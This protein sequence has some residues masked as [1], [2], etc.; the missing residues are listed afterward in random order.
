MVFCRL[1]INSP[2]I[3]CLVGTA[4]HVNHVMA[5]QIEAMRVHFGIARKGTVSCLQ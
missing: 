1:L 4:M 2:L 3:F 5:L